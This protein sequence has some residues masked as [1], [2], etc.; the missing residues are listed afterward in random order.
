VTTTASGPA[1]AVSA[2][3]DTGV[4]RPRPVVA[5]AVVG[6]FLLAFELYV[7]ARWVTGPNFTPTAPG[8]DPVPPV[9][10]FFLTFMQIATPIGAL[11][12]F[13][14]WIVRPWRREGRLT[15]DAM[16]ALAA[17]MIFFWD[18]CMNYTSITLFYN[19]HLINMGAWANGAWPGWTA[20]GGNLLPEPILIVVPAYT[21]LVFSQVM[22]MLWLLRKAK[23]RWPAMGMGRTIAVIIVGLTITDT[24]VES[25]V[26][27]MGVYAYPGGI[28]ELT[29]FAGETYQMPL[30]ET[31]FFGG[32]GF[33][34]IAVLMHFRDDKGRTV[35]ERGLERVR[36]GARAKQLIKFLAIF[37]A[38]HAAFVVLYMVPCQWLA[39]H[40]D[41]FPEG[42]P[43]YLT[44]GMCQSGAD[45]RTCPGPGVVMP[46]PAENTIF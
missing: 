39:T 27:R 8:P 21:C 18:M 13:W 4:Q 10:R 34:S 24:I 44:N 41:P 35:V 5:M 37:G 40:S 45:G 23:A 31:F 14:F 46:R 32:L 1:A 20:P 3:P 26:L 9:T 15:T 33:G 42:Y 16:F 25:T 29:L 12:C 7:L 22:F 17:G 36:A 2:A 28:R 38:V 6:A 11:V 43:S 19:S 30:T